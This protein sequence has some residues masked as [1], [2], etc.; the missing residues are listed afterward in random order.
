MLTFFTVALLLTSTYSFPLEEKPT[1]DVVQENSRPQDT[2]VPNLVLNVPAKPEKDTVNVPTQTENIQEPV[3][4]QTNPQ[5]PDAAALAQENS[6][7]QLPQEYV[8]PPGEY[9]LLQQENSAPVAEENVPVAQEKSDLDTANTFWGFG[10]WRRPYY[11]GWG[12]F[13][14]GWGGRR[15]GGWG[16]RGYGGWGGWG[17][18]GRRYGGWYW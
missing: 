16:G 6:N 18:G 17:W 14:W 9:V 3:V 5:I 7:A 13:G 15:Y 12:G 2:L 8:P 11:G 10:G 4:L 1:Q